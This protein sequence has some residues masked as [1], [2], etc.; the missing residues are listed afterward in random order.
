MEN[1]LIEAASFEQCNALEGE[2]LDK[3]PRAGHACDVALDDGQEVRVPQR[4][5]MQ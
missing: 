5:L 4:A 2:V 1:T 3:I